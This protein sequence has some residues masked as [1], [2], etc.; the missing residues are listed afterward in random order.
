[1]YFIGVTTSESAIT[2]LFPVWARILGLEDGQLIGVDAPLHADRV[3]YRRA[4]R[5]IK[6]DPLSLGAAV[7]THKVDLLE[8]TR[9]LF[10]ELDPNALLCREVSNIAKREGRLLGFAKD[11]ITAGRIL[12]EIIP[13]GHWVRT[14]GDVL[15][16][17]AG[18]TTT[19]IASNVL[20]R[21]GAADRPRRLIAIGRSASSLERLRAVLGQIAT[22]VPV[23]YVLN[24]DPAENDRMLASLPAG[25]LVV[26]ATGMGKDRPGSPITD[27]AAFPRD[28][29]AWELNYRGELGFLRQARAQASARRLHVHDGWRYFIHGWVEHIAEVFGLEV[30]QRTLAVLSEAAEHIR[31]A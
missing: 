7:T 28:G 1:M 25:S 24:E 13:V 27:R 9:D 10:D 15:C 12:D 18:G 11:P 3:V 20:G 19:A 31:A 8:A 26:N 2:R 4:V 17:G 5:Q 30:D 14:R 29:I 22:E 21:P 23:E 6:H 16:L